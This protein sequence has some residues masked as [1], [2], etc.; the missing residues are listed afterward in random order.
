MKRWIVRLISAVVLVAVAIPV[1]GAVSALNRLPDLQPWH[2]L[3]SRLEPRASELATFSLDDYLRRED[4]VFLEA[5][6]QVD[7]VVSVGADASVPNRYVRTSRSHPSR[8]TTPWNRTHVSTPPQ[9]RGGALLVHGL[10][11]GPYSMRAIAERLNADGYYTVAL[12]MQGHG[13]VPG[14]L[15][16]VEWED[17][18][19]AVRMGVRHVREK[20]GADAPLVLVG[21][22]NGGA[23]VTK[24]AL[25][26]AAGENLPAPSKLILMSPMIGV[27]PTAWL[28]R[29][30]S[31]FG[32][33]PFFE[34]ARWLDVVPEYNPF[35]YNSF[36]TNAGFQTARLT[37]A[38][39]E[40][41]KQLAASGALTR[42]PP[43][44][45][46]QS[47]IDATV[48]TP[49]VVRDLFDQLPSGGHELVM[50]DI[51][52]SAGIEPF[53]R[54]GEVLPRLIEG[55]PRRYTA[56]LITNSR[57]D[58]NEVSAMSVASGSKTLT[59][60]PLSLSWP[61]DVF[62]LSHVGIPFPEDDSVYGGASH[63]REDGSV[64]LGRVSVRGEKGVLIVPQ[65]VLMRVTWN[66]FFAYLAAR[67]DAWVAF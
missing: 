29:A 15:V 2:R 55:G 54:P 25:D 48:S 43:I 28:A 57:A 13:T 49:A 53:L 38:L 59:N 40:Q 26:V 46:F 30:I 39:Q 50:F 9:I 56:T 44:L 63:G 58:T 5:D 16:D 8:L 10:T 45:A 1:G 67:V 34:K 27:S 3:V 62:S 19:A 7:A 41:V 64:S 11:D 36:P 60:E 6:R 35:K 65:E 21:Y 51:N 66:P 4:A 17:W 61:A 12:R 18:E 24:Y 23:L 20:I 52:R 31:R 47:V 14:G 33:I 32:A 37:S 22:S 42:L